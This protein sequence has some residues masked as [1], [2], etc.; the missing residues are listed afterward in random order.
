M[1][2]GQPNVTKIGLGSNVVT[3]GPG[4]FEISRPRTTLGW[5]KAWMREHPGWFLRFASTA[6][7]REGQLLDRSPL[8]YIVCLHGWPA[9]VTA[10]AVVVTA[11]GCSL[12]LKSPF[13]YQ[14]TKY[15]FDIVH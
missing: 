10:A 8:I 5:L 15:E 4:R 7:T 13:R 3:V 11:A 2:V 14:D 1:T 9:C 6:A 12:L